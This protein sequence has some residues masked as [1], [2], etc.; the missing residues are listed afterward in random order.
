[1]AD[2]WE[3]AKCESIQE[4]WQMFEKVPEQNK[5]SCSAVHGKETLAEIKSILIVVSLLQSTYYTL[6]SKTFRHTQY[7]PTCIWQLKEKKM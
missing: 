7:F 5:V 3:S 1:M 4:A 6:M 2:V